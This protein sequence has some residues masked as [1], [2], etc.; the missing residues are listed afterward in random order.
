MIGLIAATSTNGVI[1]LNNQLP[2]DYPEDLK[3]FKE[4]TIGS[5][6]IMGRKTFER[7]WQSPSKKK[8]LCNII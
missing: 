4:T 6:I 7:Y 5:T 8:K 3:Q 2:F 1:G